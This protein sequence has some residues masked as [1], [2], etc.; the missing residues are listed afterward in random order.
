VTSSLRGS[1]ERL[2]SQYK[3]GTQVQVFV[4]PAHATEAVLRPG[5]DPG[6]LPL[7]LAFALLPLVVGI[8]MLQIA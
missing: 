4:D 5:G 6:F 1:A 2:I 8:A 7:M 3:I